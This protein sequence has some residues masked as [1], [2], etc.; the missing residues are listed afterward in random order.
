VGIKAVGITI[1]SLDQEFAALHRRSRELTETIPFETFYGSRGR[2]FR[3]GAA[4]SPG[5]NI[6]KS[7]AAVEQTFGGITANLWDDPFEWT[8]PETLS[9]RELVIEYLDEVEEV[10]RRAFLSFR[11][12]ADLR[13][14]VALPCGRN[15]SLIDLLL[16]TLARASE[17]QQR[18]IGILKTFPNEGS[19]AVS[20]NF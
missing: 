20:S 3:F 13:K 17:Y 19:A 18:A 5:E 6:L 2:A 15:S 16:D 1:A 8:L 9:T 7:A 4:H 12:E 14:E 10:R 11:Q